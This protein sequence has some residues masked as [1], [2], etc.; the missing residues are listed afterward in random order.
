MAAALKSRR[1]STASMYRNWL[2]WK[3]LELPS[4]GRKV[5]NCWGVIVSRMSNCPTTV[6]RILAIRRAVAS[7]PALSPSSRRCWSSAASC[8]TCLNHS[9]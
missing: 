4:S 1:P 6:L 8:R 2:D 7:E 9:S 5:E 3:P